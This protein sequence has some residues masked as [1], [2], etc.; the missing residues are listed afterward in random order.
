MGV[1]ASLLRRFY[2]HTYR[3]IHDPIWVSGPF[4][5]YHDLGVGFMILDHGRTISGHP[6]ASYY[7]DFDHVVKHI[8]ECR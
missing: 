1:K 8:Q 5:V 3:A 4:E 7:D 2:P 6:A